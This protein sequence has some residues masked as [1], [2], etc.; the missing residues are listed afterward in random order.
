M[1]KAYTEMATRLRPASTTTAPARTP[2]RSV[3]WMFQRFD[4]NKDGKLS[5]DEFIKARLAQFTWA[6]TNKDGAVSRDELR[7]IIVAIRDRIASPSATTPVTAA[8]TPKVQPTTSLGQAPSA[9]PATLRTSQ[10]AASVTST[11][12]AGAR[13]KA[14]LATLDA[15]NDGKITKSEYVDHAMNRFTKIDTNKDGI[16]SQD[17]L[18]AARATLVARV[19][20]ARASSTRP[21]AS[22]GRSLGVGLSRYDTDKDGKVSQAEYTQGIN[23]RFAR[24]DVDKDGVISTADVAKVSQARGTR[25][26]TP[27]AATAK[28]VAPHAVVTPA[29]KPVKPNPGVK[30]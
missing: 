20:T 21:L 27:P 14:M 16:L 15:N 19:R 9:R 29:S 8:A 12:V 3:A 30:G 6:D 23:A 11:P 1:T 2:E 28:P 26:T 7:S 18:K 24:L 17:E 22:R 4:A 25:P 5:L 10:T 13:L